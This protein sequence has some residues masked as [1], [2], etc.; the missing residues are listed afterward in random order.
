MGSDKA[1]MKLERSATAGIFRLF[2]PFDSQVWI[3]FLLLWFF[4]ATLLYFASFLD[5]KAQ[6]MKKDANTQASFTFLESLHY[7][8][9]AASQ[10]GV[11]NNPA[12]LSGKA[13]QYGWSLFMMV[14]LST[15]TAN[16]AA[17]YSK[18]S[19]DKPL[20]SIDDIIDS[21]VNLHAL[22]DMEGLHEFMRNPIIDR[23]RD[24]SRIHYSNTNI[25]TDLGKKLT[26]V[27]RVIT[28]RSI[29]MMYSEFLEDI[30]ESIDLVY[31]LE[32]SFS[33]FGMSF[34]MRKDWEFG[35]QVTNLFAFY[36]WSGYFDQLSR[37]YKN[38]KKTKREKLEPLDLKNFRGLFLIVIVIGVLAVLHQCLVFI[39]Q[40]RANSGI[41]TFH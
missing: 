33:T 27:D 4:Y 17:F 10:Y 35:D 36:G 8:S 25:N 22:Q 26:E 3:A 11:E 6:N 5:K 9:F 7:F 15:Y 29:F 38:A 41:R 30:L 32:G 14:L 34:A 12:T 2:D 24:E 23:L 40:F 19:Y 28:N 13:L 37:Q 18:E 16:L 21:N 39:T 1:I 31:T 20:G